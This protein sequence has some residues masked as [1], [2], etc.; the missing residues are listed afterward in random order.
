MAMARAC[1]LVASVVATGAWVLAATIACPY[2]ADLAGLQAVCPSHIV[3]DVLARLVPHPTWLQATDRYP[4]CAPGILKQANTSGLVCRYGD[5]LPT[6]SSAALRA[7]CN[8]EAHWL[9]YPDTC[10]V[11]ADG[12]LAIF[13]NE[14]SH[15]M[16]MA[17]EPYRPLNHTASTIVYIPLRDLGHS[18]H[19]AVPK[20]IPATDDLAVVAAS[21]LHPQLTALFADRLWTKW[22]DA[23]IRARHPAHALVH[24]EHALDVEI[25]LRRGP[26]GRMAD[27]VGRLQE[28]SEG[29]VLVPRVLGHAG[30]GVGV[31]HLH[32]E[33]AQ[34]ADDHRG[35]VAVHEARHAV[36]REVGRGR[37]HADRRRV[38]G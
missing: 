26:V 7:F 19:R 6:R 4:L 16:Q 33:R 1:V 34:P 25:G 15:A 21:C 28:P 9:L 17:S 5:R 36:H 22:L 23:R 2:V 10:D 32:E 11:Y 35:E 29:V 3:V 14:S 18:L 31:E 13:Y 12:K 8:G 20:A 24:R 30:H 27:E 38:L 37:V